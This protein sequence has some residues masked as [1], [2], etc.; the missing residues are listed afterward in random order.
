MKASDTGTTIGSSSLVNLRL[1]GSA[2]GNTFSGITTGSAGATLGSST[3]CAVLPS[4]EMKASDTGTTM[5]SS[6]LVN[7]RL[8]GSAAGNT[9]SG[10]TT[11]SAGATLGSS[12]STVAARSSYTAASAVGAESTVSSRT[13]LTLIG[14]AL[15]NTGSGIITGVGVSTFGSS[16]RVV[17][18]T[19]FS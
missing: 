2:A 13:Y 12:T 8:I 4:S 19:E 17:G 5:G 1:I 3:S 10:I 16:T 14:S 18:R 15:G 6:S 7:L 11:G 9:F